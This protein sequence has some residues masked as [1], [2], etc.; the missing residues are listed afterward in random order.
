MKRT[1]RSTFAVP[2]FKTQNADIAPLNQSQILAIVA[3]T[4]DNEPDEV[5][6]GQILNR[7]REIRWHLIAR[8]DHNDSPDFDGY[9]MLT[10]EKTES[11]QFIFGVRNLCCICPMSAPG[12]IPDHLQG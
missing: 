4:P 7:Y 5:E 9:S 12:N 11:Y 2:K 1:Y 10:F 8:L 6:I 3:F